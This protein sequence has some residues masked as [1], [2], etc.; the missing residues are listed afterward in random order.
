MLYCVSF[1]SFCVF[2]QLFIS[3][4]TYT[5]FIYFCFCFSNPKVLRKKQR[6]LE[7]TIYPVDH[8]NHLK[9]LTSHFQRVWLSKN[10]VL[11]ANINKNVCHFT[12]IDQSNTHVPHRFHFSVCAHFCFFFSNPKFYVRNCA[13]TKNWW[14]KCHSLGRRNSTRRASCFFSSILLYSHS[15]IFDDLKF[16]SYFLNYCNEKGKLREKR[17]I[18]QGKS[19]SSN[20]GFNMSL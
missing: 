6:N 5:H 1:L 11:T 10:H 4:L 14:R 18:E 15:P 3:L 9:T 2:S 13:R 8:S 17:K 16:L 20:P 19:W 12:H 7:S